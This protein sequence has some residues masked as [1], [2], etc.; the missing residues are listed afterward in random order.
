MYVTINAP[1]LQL[2]CFFYVFML[3]IRGELANFYI[4]EKNKAL[5]KKLGKEKFD[6]FVK[7]Y[8]FSHGPTYPRV[9]RKILYRDIEVLK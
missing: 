7:N 5:S 6:H 8:Y 2:E 1:V 4:F 9:N 3:I